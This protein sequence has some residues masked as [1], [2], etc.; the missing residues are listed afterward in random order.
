MSSR[1]LSFLFLLAMVTVL[2]MVASGAVPRAGARLAEAQAPAD[3]LGPTATP[4][5]ETDPPSSALAAPAAPVGADPSAGPIGAS[6]PTCVVS[7]DDMIG[8]WKGQDDLLGTVGPT[9]TGPVGFA[10]GKVRRSMSFNG[11]NVVST[12]A[13]PTVSTAVSVEAWVRPVDTGQVQSLFS[14]WT[15]VGGDNDDSY[16]LFLGVNND[17][18]W[19]TDETSTRSAVSVSAPVPQI[20]DGQFH[21]VAATWDQNQ[22]VVYLDGQ[23]VATQAS[24]GGILNPGPT[25]QFRLGSSGGPGSPLYYSGIL[26]EPTVYNR[27]LAAAEVAAIFETGSEGKCPPGDPSGTQTKLVGSDSLAGDLFGYSVAVNGTTMLIGA[28]VADISTPAGT[29]VAGGAVYV[30]ERTGTVWTQQAKLTATD[31]RAGANLGWSVALTG[32]TAVVGAPND[33]PTPGA[34]EGGSAYVFTRTGT[35]WTQQAKLVSADVATQD[36][37]GYA[38]SANGD[39]AIVGAY[40]DDTSAVDTGSAYVFT[41]T[42]TAWGQ[43]AKLVATDATASDTAGFSVA[44]S[45]DGAIVGAVQAD[46][47]G[48]NSGAA[49]VWGRSGSTWTQQGKLTPGGSAAGDAF[50]F[51]VAINGSSAIIGAPNVDGVGSNAGAAF[52]FIATGATWTQQAKL[53]AT[54][55]TGGSVFGRSV[56]INLNTALV[57]APLESTTAANAGAAY[58]FTRSGTVWGQLAKL[59]AATPA[60]N[61]L[62][63][64]DVTLNSVTAA[65]SAPNDDQLGANAGATYVYSLF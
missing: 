17:L 28:P 65:A 45:G 32:D 57:G 46:A 37:F 10:D 54:D 3:V 7:T 16:A 64:F 21:H 59:T 2:G 62:F 9:L 11:S 20:F 58:L 15:W 34:F 50:G 1:R 47:P 56:A 40:R 25:T 33:R 63:G 53:T 6:V 31:A 39:S 22:M 48:A 19:I 38:V 18:F 29:V 24:Q 26:D 30:F 44:I 51:S 23:P 13:L 4:L 52:V 27:A 61:D 36:N 5:T 12:D 49:Y 35:T 42:G 43:Q 14:R 41:R 60:V 8:W 55:A